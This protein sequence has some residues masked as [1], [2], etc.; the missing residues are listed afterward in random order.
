MSH[1]RIATGGKNLIS[2]PHQAVQTY[3]NH[4][5]GGWALDELAGGWKGSSILG[6][7]KFDE[8]LTF[9]GRG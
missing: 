7:A 6:P 2:P 4:L 9:G 1:S 5:S 3:H 8:N